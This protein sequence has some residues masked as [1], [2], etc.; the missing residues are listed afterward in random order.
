[1]SIPAVVEK[2]DQDIEVMVRAYLDKITTSLRTQGLKVEAVM[3]KGKPSER[4]LQYA[5]NSGCDL[6][7]V[8]TYGYTRAT[9]WR[10]G[11]VAMNIIRA[12]IEIPILLV[13]T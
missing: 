4:I 9:R 5:E 12:Q 3:E 6:I 10:T 7:V 2:V 8:G 11:S 1:M 13:P